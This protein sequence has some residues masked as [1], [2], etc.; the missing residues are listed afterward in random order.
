MSNDDGKR[1]I[2]VSDELLSGKGIDEPYNQQEMAQ[3]I[4]WV[5]NEDSTAQHKVPFLGQFMVD[6]VETS[7]NAVHLPNFPNDEFVYIVVGG[8]TLTSDLTKVDQTFYAGDRVLVPR[9]WAGVWR[10]HA[11]V[12]REVATVPSNYFDVSSQAQAA[13][14]GALPFII[15]PPKTPGTHQLHNGAY[16]VEAQNAGREETRAI[17]QQSDEVVHILGGTL[18]LTAAGKT[19]IFRPGDIVIK[20]NGFKGDSYVTAGYR[21]VVARAK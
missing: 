3:F 20:P 14:K 13:P 10:V 16:I 18:R 6:V 9:G 1:W 17:E 4:D 5:E 11:G 19:E 12:F 15:D 21:A 8:L 2:R 7:G